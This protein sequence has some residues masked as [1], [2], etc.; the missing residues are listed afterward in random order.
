MLGRK[1]LIAALGATLHPRFPEVGMDD[2]H[3]EFGRRWYGRRIRGL[4]ARSAGIC[5]GLIWRCYL[6][7]W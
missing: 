1:C 2:R 6:I 4:I 7:L 3:V 5:L